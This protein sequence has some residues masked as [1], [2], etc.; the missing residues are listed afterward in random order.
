[1]HSTLLEISH[2]PFKRNLLT[3]CY[4]YKE[5]TY[6]LY[7]TTPI[8]T[9]MSS[10]NKSHLVL[11]LIVSFTLILFVS[12]LDD[13]SNVP[14]ESPTSDSDGFLPLAL[15]HVTIHNRVRN[16]Q[17]LNVHC[18]S[19][20]DD[21][22]MIHIP[23]DH[24]WGFNFHVNL[25]KTTR[26]RC[27]FTWLGGGTHYFTIFKVSRDDSPSGH[28]PVCKKCIWEVGSD[29]NNPICRMSLDGSLPKCFKWEDG[30]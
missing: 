25:W 4:S 13:F 10:N 3:F 22:G 16:K 1:M 8:Y 2:P 19:S 15:K 11:L 28:Y 20:E 18:K 26:F 12:A 9:I 21:L 27:H 30:P 17:T 5:R 23:W 6:K 14:A 24:T 7:L 29:D